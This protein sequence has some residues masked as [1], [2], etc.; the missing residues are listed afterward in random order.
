M[1]RHEEIESIALLE[2]QFDLQARR[3]ERELSGIKARC[4]FV[5]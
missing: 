4:N 1:I 2:F 5:I 3:E